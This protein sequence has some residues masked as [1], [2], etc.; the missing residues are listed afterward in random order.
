VYSI[1]RKTY[2]FW[3]VL[4]QACLAV[5]QLREVV[6]LHWPRNYSQP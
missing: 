5:E 3:F 4:G 1:I 6:T 2:R